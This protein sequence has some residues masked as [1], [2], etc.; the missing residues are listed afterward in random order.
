MSVEI[1]ESSTGI[2]LKGVPLNFRGGLAVGADILAA[3][4]LED[5]LSEAAATEVLLDYREKVNEVLAQVEPQMALRD[6]KPEG[7]A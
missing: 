5:G 7:V 3:L 2:D 1:T 4:L 6:A